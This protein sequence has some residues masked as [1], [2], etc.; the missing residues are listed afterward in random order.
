[1]EALH[2]VLA[3]VLPRLLAG[4]P[5]TDEK[6]AFAWRAVVGASME[7]ATQVTLRD[8]VLHVRA[9]DANWSREV[10]RSRAVILSRLQPLLGQDHV[11]GIKVEA[12]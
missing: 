7:R 10:R 12:R 1:V 4:A 2:S 3:S 8:A 9:A 6:V 11:R 5:L